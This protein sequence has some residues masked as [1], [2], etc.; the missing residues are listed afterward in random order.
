MPSLGSDA[1][2]KVGEGLNSDG[3]AQ[4]DG[5]MAAK[6]FGE[7]LDKHSSFLRTRRC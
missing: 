2:M 3:K 7:D 6:G 4:V 5:Y 1:M